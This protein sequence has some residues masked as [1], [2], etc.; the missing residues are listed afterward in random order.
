MTRW[1]VAARQAQK[2]GTKPTEPT[3]PLPNEV[4]SVLSVL[5]EGNG[6]LENGFSR[7]VTAKIS[8]LRTAPPQPQKPQLQIKPEGD[9]N[10]KANTVLA[11]LRE[12][13]SAKELGATL[14]AYSECIAEL[15]AAKSVRFVHIQNLAA[16]KRKEFGDTLRLT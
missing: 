8:Q 4:S 15:E 10:D 7:R 9:D 11:A 2:D 1:L 13:A 6:T 12:S 16:L 5:S 14:N 3:K